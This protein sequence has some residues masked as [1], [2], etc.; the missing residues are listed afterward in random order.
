M[1]IDS[2]WLAS[3]LVY[4]I[5]NLYFFVLAGLSV[6]TVF[7]SGAHAALGLAAGGWIAAVLGL[8][9]FS[10]VGFASYYLMSPLVLYY[11]YSMFG[12]QVRIFG[13]GLRSR[14]H[15]HQQLENATNNPHD[16][17]A[18][19]Q[20]GLIYQKRRQ[21]TE[22][23]ARFERAIAIDPSEADPYLQLGRIAKDQSRFEDAIRYLTRAVSLDDKLAQNEVWRELGAAY[24]GAS[25]FDEARAALAKFTERRPYDPEGLYWY[26][27][28]L[29]QAG[30]N[31]EAED[32]FKRCIEAV[33]TMPRH[34]RAEVRKW[35]SQA[36]SEM[37]HLT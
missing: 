30:G 14:Q 22:A 16:A 8:G 15:F 3:P 27:K 6:R 25:R 9:L 32:L 36:R 19:Y 24:M 12:S 4:F 7:G 37:R 18:H 33:D 2:E 35:G 20:L 28:A 17:D 11:L 13:D 10:L 5:V 29:T 34:R 21:Y 26:G 23:L 1:A 31:A